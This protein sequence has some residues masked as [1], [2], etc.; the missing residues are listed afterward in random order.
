MNTLDRPLSP[1]ELPELIHIISSFLSLNDKI[2]ARRVN[3]IWK[4]YT[5]FTPEEKNVIFLHTI[6]SAD[7]DRVR[8]MM[9]IRDM[10]PSAARGLTSR[11]NT[12]VTQLEAAKANKPKV[13]GCRL[14]KVHLVVRSSESGFYIGGSIDFEFEKKKTRNAQHSS[15]VKGFEIPE[16]LELSTG[17]NLLIYLILRGIWKDGEWQK[18][19]NEKK[20]KIPKTFLDHPLFSKTGKGVEGVMDF[21]EGAKCS[22]E[23]VNR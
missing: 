5:K 11:S 20:L 14:Q 17:T 16:F 13:G 22:V 9:E 18:A 1:V 3:H 21:D 19:F 8:H 10:D 15:L 6:E 7:V 12:E 2:K 4:T 23:G